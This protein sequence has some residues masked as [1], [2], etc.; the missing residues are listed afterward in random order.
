VSRNHKGGIHRKVWNDAHGKIPK[1]HHI[2]HIDGNPNNNDISNLVCIT[3]EEHAKIHNDEFVKWASVGGKI[4]GEKCKELSLGIFSASPEERKQR[5]LHALSHRKFDLDSDRRK[6]EYANG[7]R[8]HWTTFYSK[9]EIH[10]KISGGDPGKSNRGKVAWNL[11]KTM[12]LSNPD[13]ANKRK[14]EAAMHRKKI[15]CRCCLKEFDPGNYKRHIKSK[16]FNQGVIN[17]II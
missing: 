3:V 5:S 8:K 10:N 17:S 4:G 13:L 6:N 11:G 15:K 14:S 9:D 2:H 12:N 7:S 1:E 16:K